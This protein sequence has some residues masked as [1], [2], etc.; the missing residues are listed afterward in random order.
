MK[1]PEAAKLKKHPILIT[2][3]NRLQTNRD[4]TGVQRVES[5]PDIK[6]KKN[7]GFVS[8]FKNI[9]VHMETPCHSKTL[10]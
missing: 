6:K 3:N 1:R 4:L 2:S 8:V 5:V 7:R 9:R 10:K